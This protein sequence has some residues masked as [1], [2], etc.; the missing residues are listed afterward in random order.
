MSLLAVYAAPV[1]GRGLQGGRCLELGVGKAAAAGTLARALATGTPPPAVLLFGVCGAYPGGR[2]RLAVRDLCLVHDD[3]LADEG[4]N[5][6]HGFRSLDAMGI[7]ITGPFV[8]DRALTAR[9]AGLLGGLPTVPAATVSACSARDDVAAELAQR[10]GAA[11]ETMEGAAVALVCR[12]FGVPLVQLRCV[13][14][15]CGARSGGEWDLAGAVA[16][17]R[18]AV[19]TLW[20]RSFP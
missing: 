9:A 2:H 3:R 18:R 15:R 19:T 10:T 1:E 11:I 7:G 8:M 20:A 12:D 6:E 14:N 13:S 16:A 5:D 4:A 17:L